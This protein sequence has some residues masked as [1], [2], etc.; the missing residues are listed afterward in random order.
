MTGVVKTVLGIEGMACSMC[1]A[2]INEAIRRNFD[3]KKVKSNR[4]KR[5][6]VIES[7]KPLD[8]ER[9]RAVIAETGYELTGIN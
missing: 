9:I 3:V 8:P 6:C 4:R 2:N 5:I 1:E 7:D